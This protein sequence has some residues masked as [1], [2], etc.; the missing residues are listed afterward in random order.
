MTDH[1]THPLEVYSS[2]TSSIFIQFASRLFSRGCAPFYI[3]TG[4]VWGLRRLHILALTCSFS[5]SLMIANLV[6]VKWYCGFSLHFHPGCGV[7]HVFMCLFTGFHVARVSYKL[8]LTTVG[9]DETTSQKC[10]LP[11]AMPVPKLRRALG[12]ASVA[13]RVKGRTMLVNEYME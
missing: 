12:A 4:D 11:C 8:V 1:T 10:L 6:D 5:S 3:H 13:Y 2:V 7:E 9:P